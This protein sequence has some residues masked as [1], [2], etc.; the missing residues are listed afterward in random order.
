[1]AGTAKKVRRLEICAAPRRT[2]LQTVLRQLEIDRRSHVQRDRNETI[3]RLKIQGGF[4]GS[5]NALSGRCRARGIALRLYTVDVD[6]NQA[7][8]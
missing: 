6:V 1:M 8:V 7:F 2:L 4:S 5:H 3:C